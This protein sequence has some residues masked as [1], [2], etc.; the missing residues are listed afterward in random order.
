MLTDSRILRADFFLIPDFL[1]VP[2]LTS[3]EDYPA[4]RWGKEASMA[5]VEEV[6][7]VHSDDAAN[8]LLGEGWELY[9]AIGPVAAEGT[10]AAMG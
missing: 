9:A 6:R 1:S 10:Q 5:N 4:E 8:E 3:A 2:P 7:T